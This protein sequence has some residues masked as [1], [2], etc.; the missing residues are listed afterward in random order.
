[1][2]FR[3]LLS[4]ALAFS[5]T[6]AS[7][8]AKRPIRYGD[9][10]PE[11]RAVLGQQGIHEADFDSFVRTINQETAK[12]ETEGEYDHLVYF[13]LQSMRFTKRPK[14]EPAL[15]A[16]ELVENLNSEEKA[17]YLS[18]KTYL[19]P[20]EKFPASASLRFK[21]FIKVIKSPVRDERLSY[22]RG[23]VHKNVKPSDSMFSQLYAEYARSMRFLYKK[24]FASREISDPRDAAGFVSSLYQDRGHST[25]TQIEANFPVYVAL[26]ALK[27]ERPSLRLDN[28]LIVGPG[29]DFAPRTDLIDAF[30]PQSYQPFMIADALL[31]LKLSDREKLRIHCVD[32]NDRVIDYLQRFP[33][34]SST[35]LSIISGVTD[36]ERHRLSSDYKNYFGDLGKSIG[37]ESRLDSLPAE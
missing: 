36:N 32:I 25:D 35:Q 7:E 4:V 29:L 11:L 20:I 26:A 13:V 30:D 18:D 15:S 16:H 9:I 12:R 22:L 6:I 27:A 19:P 2:R 37:V 17:H 10:P 21:D 24:E 33:T 28:V 14:V 3:L 5:L 1:M 8:L 23:F 34:R 31:G